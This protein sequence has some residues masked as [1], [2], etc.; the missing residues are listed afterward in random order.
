[1]QFA[2]V[3]TLRRLCPDDSDPGEQAL[4]VVASLPGTLE[5]NEETSWGFVDV[6]NDGN[7]VIYRAQFSSNNV[8]VYKHIG[9]D[10][11]V[12]FGPFLTSGENDAGILGGVADRPAWGNSAEKFRIWDES[13]GNFRTVTNVIAAT[14]TGDSY[15]WTLKGDYLYT[16]SGFATIGGC[17]DVKIRR[18]DISEA[19]ATNDTPYENAD[20]QWVFAM[21]AALNYLYVLLYNATAGQNQIVRFNYGEPITIDTSWNVGNDDTESMYVVS[22]NLIYYTSQ[23]G[24]TLSV[25]K[26]VNGG[27]P[28]L[29]DPA[30][31]GF[32]GVTLQGRCTGFPEWKNLFYKTVG[33]AGFL[34]YG[35]NGNIGTSRLLKIGP[36]YCA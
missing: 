33:N 13:L 29:V 35:S 18:H 30:V 6:D 9:V 17:G 31:A 23:V 36:I 27:S 1:M 11:R 22:D 10:K 24:S 21:H 12:A 26:I 19:A 2:A 28:A 5:D 25:W 15:I 4:S 34:Y 7:E 3:S 32:G 20:F 16:A 8:Q 14:P